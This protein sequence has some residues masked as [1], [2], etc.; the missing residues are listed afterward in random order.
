MASSAE[1]ELLDERECVVQWRFQ[2]LLAAG[3][4]PQDALILA[5]NLEVD[6][7]LATDLLRCG[8]PHE[9]ALRILL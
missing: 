9:T 6:L 5:A 2:E 7:H 8:C 4:E 1:F 3:Y